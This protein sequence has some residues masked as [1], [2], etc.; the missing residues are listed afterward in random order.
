MHM[1]SLLQLLFAVV[2]LA[3]TA[4]PGF[5][6]RKPTTEERAKIEAV[7]REQGYTRWGEI[8][9]DEDDQT[10][11]VDDAVAKDGRE[12]DLTL[13]KNFSIIARDSDD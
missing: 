12:Y 1:K 8:E 4:M 10:W 9:L 13:D 11:D 5:A 3:A 6:D 7:L 2:F